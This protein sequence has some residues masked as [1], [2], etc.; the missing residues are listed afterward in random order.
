VLHIHL[1]AHHT[2]EKLTQDD[3][4]HAMDEVLAQLQEVGLAPGP[5][6]ETALCDGPPH[7]GIINEA[8]IREVDLIVIAKHGR[9]E[10]RARLLGRTTE[11]VVRNAPCPVLLVSED[12]FDLP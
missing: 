7:C 10:D 4:W 3:E 9:N 12:D 6:V 1:P 11:N 5:E 2:G 8:I